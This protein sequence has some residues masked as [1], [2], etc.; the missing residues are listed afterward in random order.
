MTRR[1]LGTALAAMVGS[2]GAVVIAAGPASAYC[3]TG[4]TK[5]NNTTYSK[6]LGVD[7]SFPTAMRTGLSNGL[8]Q[9]NRSGSTLRYTT[10]DYTSGWM[11][12]AFRGSHSYSPLMGNAPGYAQTMVSGSTHSGGNL[13]LSNRFSWVNGSQNISGGVADVQTVAVHEVGHFTGLAHPWIGHCT[14]GTSYTPAEQASVMTTINTGT[15]RT[16]N[17][18]DVA[19][20]TA[21]Y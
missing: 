7:P 3:R 5:W 19:G 18:D 4:M 12:Y 13:I 15:R 20:V 16:L 10:P 17:S 8:T 14:D 11:I 1:I 6:T 2:V 21:I 9:W